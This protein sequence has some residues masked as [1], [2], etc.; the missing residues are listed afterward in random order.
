MNNGILWVL[1]ELFQLLTFLLRYGAAFSDLWDPN[2]H[3]IQSLQLP[4]T[5]TLDRAHDYGYSAPAATIWCAESDGTRTIINDRHVIL[6]R[7]SI[8]IFSEQYFADKEGKGLRLLPY[9]L[10]QRMF[11]HENLGGFRARI[12]AG[13]ADASIFDKDRGMT[14]IHDEYVKKGVRFTRADKRPGSRERGYIMI[15]QRLKAAATRNPEQPWLLVHRNCVNL[16]SQLP[17]LPISP[18]NPQDVDSSANDHIYDAVKYRM[19]KSAQIAEAS[20]VIGY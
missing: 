19:L 20:G 1:Q 11:D 3:V 2:V 17:E 6:P 13:P 4:R 10:G 16:I 8:V 18:E 9:E 15:R 5:W 12:Q 14:S 7:K